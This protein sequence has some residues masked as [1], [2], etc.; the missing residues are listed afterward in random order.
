MGMFGKN[1]CIQ[2][3]MEIGKNVVKKSGK[4]FCS[5]EH[6]NEYAR[7]SEEGYHCCC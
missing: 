5:E 3:G 7:R 1:I 2:C 4:F 6:A